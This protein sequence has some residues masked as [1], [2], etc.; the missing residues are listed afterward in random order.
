[1][2][3]ELLLPD[4]DDTDAAEFWN[5]RLALVD[6]EP[7]RMSSNSALNTAQTP[8]AAQV[9]FYMTPVRLTIL[10]VVMLVLLGLAFFAGMM[11]GRG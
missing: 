8:L 11:V 10:S 7:V 5:R 3:G 4:I 1:M 9:G 2:A 6:V